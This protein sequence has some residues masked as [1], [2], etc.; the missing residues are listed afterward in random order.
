MCPEL[1]LFGGMAVAILGFASGYFFGLWEAR[2]V[3][4]RHIPEGGER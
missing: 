2:R 1:F 4:N 3:I